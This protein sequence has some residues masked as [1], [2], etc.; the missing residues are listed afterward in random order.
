VPTSVSDSETIPGSTLH[1]VDP[2]GYWVS[3]ELQCHDGQG[4][5]SNADFGPGGGMSLEAAV[6]RL[7]DQ[8]AV[9]GDVIV[10]VGYPNAFSPEFALSRDGRLIVL[11]KP[12]RVSQDRW[13]PSEANGCSGEDRVKG[14]FH[15]PI[16]NR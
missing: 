10:Q 14:G 13:L 12:L 5:G 8:Y 6:H 3:D 16:R 9:P 11:A 7:L 1:V 2:R 15:A 4:F